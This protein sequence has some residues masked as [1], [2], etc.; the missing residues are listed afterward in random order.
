MEIKTTFSDG[1]RKG[2]EAKAIIFGDK[3]NIPNARIVMDMEE[4]IWDKNWAEKNRQQALYYMYRGLAKNDEDRQKMKS[5]GLRFDM[6]DSFPCSLGQ[7]YNKTAGHYHSLVPGTNLSYPEV[8][9]LIRGK[10]YYLMQ[11]VKGDEVI[12]V[13]AVK[14]GSGDKVIV[15]PD[16][17]HFSIF[18]SPEGI[19]ESNWTS[20]NSLS[21][22]EKVKEKKGAA[23]YA[24]IDEQSKDGVRWEKNNHYSSVPPLRFLPPTNFADLGLSKDSDM[25]ELVN[26][27]KKLDYLNKPQNHEELWNRILKAK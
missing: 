12:D 6:L 4:T 13:Y 5:S 23:Y 1:G 2:D 10:M 15:P 17:G 7:E 27:L 3:K 8:Y 22:Y 20:D 19:R 11:K 25:Y 21:G 24:L 9:G 18:L 16:Y 26:D 14:A